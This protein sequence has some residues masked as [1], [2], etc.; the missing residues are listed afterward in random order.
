MHYGDLNRIEDVTKFRWNIIFCL[1]NGEKETVF[2]FL[3]L[4]KNGLEQTIDIKN[5]AQERHIPFI[6]GE[7][8]Q[9]KLKWLQ[10]E[11]ELEKPDNDLRI[12]NCSRYK[13]MNSEKPCL[14]G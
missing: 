3:S 9:E 8:D 2:H 7:M 6:V 11:L 12:M 4:Y 14:Y 5:V 1:Y 10:L 13:H